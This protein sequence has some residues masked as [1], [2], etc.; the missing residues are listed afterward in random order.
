MLDGASP[1]NGTIACTFLLPVSCAQVHNACSGITC[2]SPPAVTIATGLDQPPSLACDKLQVYMGVLC[3]SPTC[4]I[5]HPCSCTPARAAGSLLAAKQLCLSAEP[6]AVD[7]ATP[8]TVQSPVPLEVMGM[9]TSSRRGQ[10]RGLYR[11]TVKPWPLRVASTVGSQTLAF[12]KGQICRSS[13][14]AS[15]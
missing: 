3:S 14:S 4:Q 6:K 12:R 11:A 15:P 5:S 8:E 9:R 2:Y 13:A 10:A 7:C 1:A